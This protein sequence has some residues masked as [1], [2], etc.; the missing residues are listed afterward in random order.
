MI[1]NSPNYALEADARQHL[2]EKFGRFVKDFPFLALGE[3]N[4]FSHNSI[5]DTT[6]KVTA[7][8]HG[9]EAIVVSRKFGE[10]F[11]HFQDGGATF[12]RR[13]AFS[14]QNSRHGVF[15]GDIN[16][17]SR[18]SS[19]CKG[20]CSRTGWSKNRSGRSCQNTGSYGEWL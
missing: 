8:V 17:E 11:E 19:S 18:S 2:I 6:D 12:E 3:F 13:K 9:K 1:E 7:K 4:N 5:A 10:L 16:G 14:G 20:I 15:F